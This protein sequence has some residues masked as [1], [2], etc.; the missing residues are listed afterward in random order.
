MPAITRA[1]VESR[2]ESVALCARDPN[3]DDMLEDAEQLAEQ[4][5]AVPYLCRSVQGFRVRVLTVYCWF[6]V[7]KPTHLRVGTHH[8]QFAAHAWVQVSPRV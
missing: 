2:L 4:M 1:Y 3:L 7:L 8:H 5:D 6:L